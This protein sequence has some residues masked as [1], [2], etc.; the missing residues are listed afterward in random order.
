M[1]VMRELLIPDSRKWFVTPDLGT[2]VLTVF[3]DRHVTWTSCTV[4][5]NDKN[6]EVNLVVWLECEVVSEVGKSKVRFCSSH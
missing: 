2:N 4:I 1:C 3:G 6:C 5:M